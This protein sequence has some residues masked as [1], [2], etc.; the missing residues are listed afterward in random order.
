MI[1][2]KDKI[3]ASIDIS[4]YKYYTKFIDYHCNLF[5]KIMSFDNNKCIF[6]MFI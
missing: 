6:N 3:V 2:T 4:K 1:I 5:Y